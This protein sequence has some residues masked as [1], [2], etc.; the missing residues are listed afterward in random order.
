MWHEMTLPESSVAC[1]QFVIYNHQ[2]CPQV[3]GDVTSLAP[4]CNHSL[5]VYKEDLFI[6]LSSKLN[7]TGGVTN[8]DSRKALYNSKYLLFNIFNFDM[9]SPPKHVECVG[10]ASSLFFTST[11][12]ERPVHHFA[13]CILLPGLISGVDCMIIFYTIIKMVFNDATFPQYSITTSLSK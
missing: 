2:H 8:H 13:S 9:L 4:H 1:Q 5:K 7:H 11:V 12:M 10:N 6:I 3:L